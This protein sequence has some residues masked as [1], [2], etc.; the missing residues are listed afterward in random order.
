MYEDRVLAFVDVLGFSEAVKG[1]IKDDREVAEETLRISQLIDGIQ[2]DLDIH[3][4]RSKE[5]FKFT[6]EQIKMVSGTRV[7]NQ[8][9]DSIVL[10]FSIK[11]ESGI[12]LM[13][14]DILFLHVT[15][16]Q[17]NFLLRGAI[18]R[19]KLLHTQEKIFGPA[20]VEA[21]EM[22]RN[23]AIYPRIVLDEEIIELSRKYFGKQNG[24]DTEEH[25]VRSL[26]K[27]DF[28]GMYYIDYFEAIET[29]LDNQIEDMPEYLSR[30]RTIIM[31]ISRMKNPSIR[32]K[33]L[34]LKEKYN[35]TLGAYKKAYSVKAVKA[36][37]PEVADAFKKMAKI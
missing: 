26:L 25:F 24:P 21:Y 19:N 35:E 16:L 17:H 34:W 4:K 28:D 20:L 5:I 18:V 37:F 32:S 6:D 2:S 30:L 22:E 10:S 31:K 36:K 11:E 33:F 29:E 12:F 23:L 9:S 13:L 8:F 14:L 7:V 1:T 27:R 15:A 3:N